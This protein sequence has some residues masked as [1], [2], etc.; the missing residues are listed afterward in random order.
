MSFYHELPYPVFVANGSVV[1]SGGTESLKPGQIGLFDASTYQALPAG[2]NAVEHPEVFIAGGSWHSKD[3]LTKF[4]GG[5]TQSI[6]TQHFLGRDVTEFARSLPNDLKNDVVQ[7]GWDGVNEC[8]GLHFECGKSYFYKVSVS[9]EDVFR[10]YSRPLYRYITLQ[11]ECCADTNCTDGCTTDVDNVV[12]SKK[13]ADLIQNDVE[14]KYF[15]KSEAVV[16]SYSAPSATHRVYQLAICDNGD[17]FALSQVQKTYSTRKIERVNRVDSTSYYQTCGLISDGAPAA[18]TPVD[19]ILLAVCGSCPSGY[20]SV[21]ARDYYIIER[22]LTPTTDLDDST[23]QATYAATI[24][25]AYSGITGSG[26][27]LG[28]NNGT[29][30][31]QIAVTAGTTVTHLNNTADII[32]KGASEPAK[33]TPPAGSSVSWTTVE[34]RYRATRTLCTTFIKPCDSANRLTEVQAFYASN[35]EIVAN[36]VVLSQSGTCSDTYTLDQ[37][38]NECIK[39]GCEAPATVT[40]NEVPSFEGHVWTECPCPESSEPDT[41]SQT[42]VRLTGAFVDT[43]FGNCSFTPT[44]YY[45]QRPVRINISQVSNLDG[46]PCDTGA[47]KVTKMQFGEVSSQSGEWLIRQYLKAASLEA[48]NIWDLDPRMR[49]A[50]DQQVLGFI[51]R[52]KRYIVYYVVYKQNRNTNWENMQPREKYETI[53]AFPEGTDTATFEQVF[54][55]YFAQNGA[56]MK[57]RGKK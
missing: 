22:P 11:T 57:D 52:T 13:L 37:Y 45:S 30:V 10:T 33:C 24:V 54:G 4:L 38:S 35:S 5:L 9:G 56:I 41:T 23:A 50:F 51:D 18:F 20:T 3:S 53:V 17:A 2:A 34:D 36:S 14:L 27:F 25:T 39:D 6:K 19:P 8:D 47:A 46:A 16:S 15:I 48:Y 12:Y 44:D 43:R 21:S 55:G 40:Y 1:T 26:T 31:V 7:I 32:I 49:E 28:I 42:A 29:A